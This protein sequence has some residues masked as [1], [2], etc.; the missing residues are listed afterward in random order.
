MGGPHARDHAKV[1]LVD[2]YQRLEQGNA[3]PRICLPQGSGKVPA[4]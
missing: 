1:V 2:A 4:L 3:M